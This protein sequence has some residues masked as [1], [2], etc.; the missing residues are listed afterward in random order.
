MPDQE[1][2]DGPNEFDIARKRAK[3]TATGTLQQKKQ[4]LKRRAVQLGGGTGRGTLLKAEKG[5]EREFGEEVQAAEEVIG[6]EERK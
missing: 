5:A 1:L 3:K 4:A 6:A 2:G